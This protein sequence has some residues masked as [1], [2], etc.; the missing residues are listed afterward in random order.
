MAHSRTIVA[1]LVAPLIVPVGL[2]IAAVVS[3]GDS[4]SSLTDF[5][6]L[7]VLFSLYALP[8]AYVFELVLG[9]PA[10][11]LF[12]RYEIRAWSAFAVGGAALG[13]TYFVAYA[14]AKHLAA[15]I[16]AYDFVRH[17]FTR[18]INPLSLW[19]ALLAGLA[20]AILFRAIVFPR[21]TS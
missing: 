13:M 6:G 2:S 14:V 10:W 1:F 19:L 9:L 5:P 16:M 17:P 11:L 18:D 4:P 3:P 12:R 21:Q 20:S 15:R 8:P 7:L